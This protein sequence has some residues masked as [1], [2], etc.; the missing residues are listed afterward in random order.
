M[1]YIFHIKFA[2]Q[3][4]LVYFLYSYQNYLLIFLHQLLF[5]MF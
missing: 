3:Q 1:V 4:L 5:L 2:K